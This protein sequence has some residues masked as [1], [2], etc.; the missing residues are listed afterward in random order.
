MIVC[1]SAMGVAPHKPTY[2]PRAR[3]AVSMTMAA[4]VIVPGSVVSDALEPVSSLKSE[5]QLCR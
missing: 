2:S 5:D 4:L 3:S 1:A